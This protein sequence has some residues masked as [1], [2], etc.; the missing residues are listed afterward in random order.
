[1]ANI[2]I[3]GPLLTQSG[4]GVHS[5]QIFKWALSRDHNIS[6]QL[7]PWGVTPWYL[8]HEECNGLIGKIMK[9]TGENVYRPDISIQVQLPNEWDPNLCAKNIGVTA[10]IE[11]NICS[12]KWIEA[13]RAM[14]KVIVPSRFTKNTF[15]TCGYGDAI[16]VPE[17]F[18]EECLPDHPISPIPE[19]DKINTQKNFLVFGQLTGAN[20]EF[21]RK[22]TWHSIKWFLETFEKNPDVGLIIKTNSGTNCK[23]DKRVTTRKLKNYIKEFKTDNT[24]CKIY[25][26]HG[27]L[28]NDLVAS[29]Y[30]SDKLTGIIS[31]TRGEGFGLPMIEAAACGL[32]VLATN[33]SGHRD[34]LGKTN[35]L[36]VDYSLKPVIREKLDGNMFVPGAMWATADERSFK[37]QLK[38]LYKNSEHYKR[39]ANLLCKKLHVEFGFNKI[40]SEYDKVLCLI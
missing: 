40:A 33:W 14:T 23:M 11:T 17:T 35:W 24:K 34:F 30:K 10:G 20:P 1:M 38:A 19:L 22:N 28:K 32:P 7:T 29:L 26:L 39:K 4:Y 9:R 6:V 37:K 31:A 27:Y 21:D 25:L 18:I 3:R 5:R 12:P 36:P 8:D 16:V 2:L 13:C 15:A